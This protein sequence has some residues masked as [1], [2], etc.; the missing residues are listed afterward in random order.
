MWCK[1]EKKA[2][3]KYGDTNSWDV[4]KVTDM[5]HMFK[6]CKFNG[7][8]SKWNFSSLIY[9]KEFILKY[10]NK[11]SKEE[12][13]KC[14]D[15]ICNVYYEKIESKYVKCDTCKNVF[16]YSIK[17]EWINDK[18]ICPMCSSEWTNNIMYIMVN[19]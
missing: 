10:I 6:Y 2:R 11:K 13:V 9:E 15:L 7:D 19:E 12:I 18:S 3:K 14:E 8:I 17:E 4:S 5:S 16:D 1:N